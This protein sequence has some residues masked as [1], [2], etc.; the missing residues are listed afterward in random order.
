MPRPRVPDKPSIEGLEAKWQARWQA[1][2]TYRFDPARPRAGVYSID[3]PPLTTSGS[4]HAGHVYSYTHTDLVARF[5]RMRGKTV[6][7][8]VGW[9]DNGLPTERRVE[10]HFGVRCDPSVGDDPAFRP[11]EAWDP[12]RPGEKVPVSRSNF[13]ELCERLAREDERAFEALWR[14]LGLSVEWSRAY[15]TI[16]HRARLVS[17]RSFLRL[18]AR[19][20]AYQ[21][22]APTLWDVTFRT[23]VAQAELVDR[24]IPGAA[25]WLRFSVTPPARATEEVVVE[26]TRPELLPACVALVAHPGDPRYRHLVGGRARTPL[27]GVEVPVLAH[28]LAKPDK[29]TGIAM[30]CTFGDTTDVVWWRELRLEV[31]SIVTRDGRLRADPPPGVPAGP[32]WEALAG[33]DVA[34]ARRRI[35]E[36]LAA[37]G[38]LVE[39]PQPITHAVAFYERGERP[40]EIVTSR[41]WFIRLLAHRERLLALGRQ[42]DWHPPFMRRRYEDWV[43]GLNGD[44]LVSRQRCFG[45]PIPLWYRVAADGTADHEQPILPSEDRLPVDPSTDVPDGYDAAD[46]GRPGGFAADPDVMDTW[47]TSSLTPQIAG[48]EGEEPELFGRVFPMD[49]RPQ[50]HEIIRTWLVYTT[51][52]SELEYGTLPWSHAAISGWVLDPDRRKLSKSLGNVVTPTEPLERYGADALRYWA[53]GGR[54]GQDTVMDEEQ[55]RVGRR[56]AIK[57]LNASRFVLTRLAEGGAAGAEAGAPEAMAAAG[58]AGPPVGVATDPLDL[59]MLAGLDQVIAE[60]TAALEAYDHT[61]ALERVEAF[62][63]HFCDDYLELVKDRAYGARG[64]AA[65]ASAEH[66]LERALSTLLRLLAPFL[67]YVTEEVWSWW[68]EGSVHLAPWPERLPAGQ[69]GDPAPLEVASEVLRAVRRAKTGARRSMRSPVAR[70]LVRD[71]PPRL[72]ALVLAEDDLLAAGAIAVLERSAATGLEVEVELAPVVPR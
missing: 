7:Y 17:Q 54:L 52:R 70:V 48:G 30:I 56:L 23:A 61:R 60:A 59:A 27:L 4:L 53:A 66:A 55:V 71:T 50:A 45:V 35:V 24:D 58:A 36:L 25:Y 44:W 16:G 20:E 21:A 72:A 49:L 33:T 28:R 9:D 43:E 18:L 39:P 32:V 41:Q 22:E 31:R 19:G 46:R 64:E 67:P 8:P 57:V 3:T 62:F 6:F 2:G 5:Q 26:T 63:W 14:R 15:T 29:G 40:L 1:E 13:I 34:E 69:L 11:P 68:R 38:D 65:R 37:S 47:A 10:G 42:L 12:S 51:L